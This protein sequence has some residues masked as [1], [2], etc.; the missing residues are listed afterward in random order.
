[1]DSDRQELLPDGNIRSTGH[2][3]AVNGDMVIDADK[4]VYY[5]CYVNSHI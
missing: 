2:V 1:M 5:Q 3:H 4:A